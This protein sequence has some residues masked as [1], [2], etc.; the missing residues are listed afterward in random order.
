MKKFVIIDG[1]AILHRAWHALPPTMMT[2]DGTIVNAVYG[3]AS[4]FLKMIVDLKPDYMA[5][6]WDTKAKTLR[7]EKYEEYKATRK[8]KEQELYDQIPMIQELVEAFNVPNVMKDGY[9]ADDVIGTLATRAKQH[10]N[11]QTIVVTGDMDI[12]QLIDDRTRVCALKKGISET[13]IYD[14]EAVRL[15]YGLTP[16]QM[17]DYKALVGDPSDN[18]PGVKGIGEKSAT[19]LLATYQSLDRLYAAIE[20][21]ETEGIK[22]AQ[23]KKLIEGKKSAY[24]AQELSRIICDVP[25]KFDFEEA[26]Y[27]TFDVQTVAGVFQKFGF[28]SLLGRLPQ[29]KIAK[30]EEITSHINP[31]YHLVDSKQ[32]A[33]AMILALSTAKVFAFDTETTGLRPFEDKLLGLSI[34][35]KKGEAY[36]V[37]TKAITPALKKLFADTSI[38]KVAHH[39]KFDVEFLRRAGFEINNLVFDTKIAA[40]LLNPGQRNTGLKELAFTEL[41]EQMVML[42]ELLGS[43]KKRLTMQQLFEQKLDA[44]SQYACADADMTLRLYPILEKRLKEEELLSVMNDIEMPLIHIL[45]TIEQYGVLLNVKFLQKISEEMGERINQLEKKIYSLAGMEFN[46]DS[47]S[48]LAEVLF[49]RLKLPTKGIKKTKSGFSTAAPE[50]EKLAAKHPMLRLISEYREKA[51]LKS[52]YVDALPKL[53]NKETGRLHTYFNQTVAA[54]GRLSSSDPNLQ[55]IPIRTEEGKK[56]REAFIAPKGYKLVSADYSQ[57][58]LRVV[59]SLAKDKEMIDA[60]RSGVD[61]HKRTAANIHGIDIEEVT[62]EMRYAAKAINFGII[63]GQGPFGLSQ[64]ADISLDE[65]RDF[66]DRYFQIHRPI[67]RYLESMKE[68]ARKNGYV[69]TLFGRRRYIPE[70]NSTVAVV[71][72][73]AERIAINMPIQG[74]AADI[75]KFAMI[76]LQ[77]FIDKHYKPDE[78]KMLLT[79]HDE[80]VFEVRDDLVDR[81]AHEVDKIMEKPKQITLDVPIKVETEVGQNWGDMEVYY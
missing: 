9:E 18:I 48:Q 55:N 25:V 50:L 31:K 41:G 2:P 1:N 75:L 8:V 49:T 24:L 4:I 29:P 32:A 5:V 56:I 65:A 79:V 15:R 6:A 69:Q 37:T 67:E 17:V 58:E 20:A 7:A 13:L 36:F 26:V 28:K 38:K 22:P 72:A 10:E 30:T 11:I 57:I 59:A 39:A 3:F 76:D 54:T 35:A 19:G 80:L 66:I 16:E 40:Y 44:L 23:L 77:A 61:I 42:D 43:G 33:E 12:L 14:A 21:G 45:A 34:S 46:I 60:F 78:V 73:A 47:P 70:I 64:V 63:Y 81:F 53:V 74:T 51:K 71:R 68:M 52:T 62:D 27:G